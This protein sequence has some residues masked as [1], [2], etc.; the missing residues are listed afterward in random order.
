[1]EVIVA[2]D[3]NGDNRKGIYK[4]C[5]HCEQDF[6]TRLDQEK[7][8]CSLHCSSSSRKTAITLVCAYCSKD[9]VRKKS[10]YAKNQT[11]KVFCDKWCKSEYYGSVT[12][13]EYR[14]LFAGDVECRRCGYNEF[15]CGVDIHHIDGD[16]ANNDVAN[17]LPLCAPCHRALHCGLW[18]LEDLEGRQLMVCCSNLESCPGLIPGESSI[19]SPSACW[20]V[21]GAP[22][23]ECER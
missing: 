12:N 5:C 9:V 18:E 7:K 8:F 22:G 13:S 21:S 11:G 16:R 15:K 17:L 4:K 19:P 23:P 14:L 2:H 3:A 10:R 1:M 6:F 20:N